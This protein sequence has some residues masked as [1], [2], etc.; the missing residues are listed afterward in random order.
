MCTRIGA[1]VGNNFHIRSDSCRNSL[2]Q[3]RLKVWELKGSAR[4]NLKFSGCGLQE[5]GGFRT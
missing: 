5:F 2:P 1:Y 3:G 4:C